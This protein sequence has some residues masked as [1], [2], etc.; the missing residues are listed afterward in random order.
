MFFSVIIPVYNV[1]PYLARAVDSILKQ[2]Y[3]GEFEIIL[4][5]DGS[6][7]K[8]GSI[9]D[10]YA[11]RDT[12][13]RVIHKKNGGLS[14]ARNAGMEIAVGEY[15]VFLDSDDWFDADALAVFHQILKQNPVDILSFF[16][17]IVFPMR[18]VGCGRELDCLKGVPLKMDEFLKTCL[19]GPEVPA[20]VWKRAFFQKNQLHF[21]A[22]IFCEDELFSAQ[23]ACV[24]KT[25][26]VIDY[27]GYNYFQSENSI[28][29][30][31][32]A[33][34]QD[35]FFQDMCFVLERLRNLSMEVQD[36]TK[37]QN[38]QLRINHLVFRFFAQLISPEISFGR[39]QKIWGRLKKERFLP[40]QP[41]R[42]SAGYR[43]YRLL[44]CLRCPLC[45]FRLIFS[46]VLGL[47]SVK[48][49]LRR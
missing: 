22:G 7:D 36:P 11:Q 42:G 37:S 31:K 44:T 26:M 25:I 48:R 5:D 35:R 14:S 12:R 28:T 23:A 1:E 6:T 40:L 49:R 43:F 2:D 34:R 29:R 41:W 15:I 30:T 13:I 18:V 19:L 21:T 16:Y 8:S 17:K 38:V 20:I 32:N 45:V 24:A 39:A 33:A 4:I 9:C 27:Y 47:G 3:S 10:D 46:V